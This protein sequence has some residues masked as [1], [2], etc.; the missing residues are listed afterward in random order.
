MRWSGKHFK[1]D[2]PPN[3]LTGSTAGGPQEPLPPPKVRV[4]SHGCL[5]KLALSALRL[6]NSRVMTQ[7]CFFFFVLA[8]SFMLFRAWCPVWIQPWCDFK[9][10]SGSNQ[11]NFFSCA[12]MQHSSKYYWLQTNASPILF[13]ILQKPFINKHI[14]QTRNL[15]QGPMEAH[16][17]LLQ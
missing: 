2:E 12:Q 14:S 3:A 15:S 5:S 11:D 6:S 10:S 1:Q 13:T 17:C 7:E 8:G 9:I 16:P 4:W